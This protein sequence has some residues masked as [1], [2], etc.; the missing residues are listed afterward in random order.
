METRDILCQFCDV[1]VGECSKPEGTTD[2]EWNSVLKG[3]C[4]SNQS[5]ISQIPTE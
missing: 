5:C 2:N 4:C 1:K 3:Y